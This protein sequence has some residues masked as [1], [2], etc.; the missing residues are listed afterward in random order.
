M[1]GLHFSLGYSC[2]KFVTFLP[3]VKVAE[4]P[5]PVAP[6]PL[7]VYDIN[8]WFPE[9]DIVVGRVFPVKTFK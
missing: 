2:I 9:D 7:F 4:N 1:F 3:N 8:I 6:S 5:F